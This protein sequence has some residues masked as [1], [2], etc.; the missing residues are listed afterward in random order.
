MKQYLH[1]GAFVNLCYVAT[2]VTLFFLSFHV[3]EETAIG[4]AMHLIGCAL[5]C[6]G[7]HRRWCRQICEGECH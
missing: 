6:A 5:S 4:G 2:G 7:F 3:G 1:R